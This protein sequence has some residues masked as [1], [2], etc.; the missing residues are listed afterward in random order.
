M[1]IYA[2]VEIAVGSSRVCSIIAEL[3]VVLMAEE[4]QENELVEEEEVTQIPG[5]A[6]AVSLDL[7]DDFIRWM[8]WKTDPAMKMTEVPTGE[9]DED[10]IYS[11]RSKLYRF[12]DGEWKERGLG[13]SKLLR[14]RENGK[15]RFMMR[16]EKTGKI[17][18]NHY[19]YDYPPYCELKLN[20]GSDK[21]WVWTTMDYSEDEVQV[22]QFALRFK[23][24]D[25]AQQFFDAFNNA[26]DENAKACETGTEPK[27]REAKPSQ[28]SQP[29]P[30][31]AAPKAEV[32]AAPAPQPD[33]NP[34]AGPHLPLVAG[35]VQIGSGT[36]A[37][38]GS[39][40]GGSLFGSA[41]G[42]TTNGSLFGSN[43]S[44]SATAGSSTGGSLFG[45][46]LGSTTNGSLRGPRGLADLD[47]GGL[48]SGGL[49]GSTSGGGL[50]GQPAAQASGKTAETLFSTLPG[51]KAFNSSRMSNCTPGPLPESRPFCC[52]IR[53]RNFQREVFLL[54]IG[55]SHGT[56][57]GRQKLATKTP[58]EWKPG[59][60]LF[61]ADANT[62][63]SN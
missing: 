14:H 51:A 40:T 54:D 56:Y 3:L 43:N 28:P 57:L 30:E 49:F 15:I 60:V 5:W 13:E 41:L 44:G 36:G 12:K 34:F 20:T 31:P 2:D 33:G 46:A 10:E 63:P 23:E 8:H 1:I 39:S 22:E 7:Q 24:V 19:P 29:V 62:E 59:V 52:G 32:A 42:S 18:A 11:Q 45:S 26:K 38:A 27:E 25:L 6:P 47:W 21:C 4:T 55:S 16:Q 50:W 53:L 61:F 48:F 37:T 17:V 35:P 58:K 9:E